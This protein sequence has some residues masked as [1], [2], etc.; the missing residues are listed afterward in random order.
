[1]AST[2]DD[3]KQALVIDHGSFEIQAGFAEED[4][5]RTAF[6]TLVGRPRHKNIAGLSNTLADSYV[7]DEAQRKRG[8]LTLTYPIERGVVTKWDDMEAVWSHT[9]SELK[10][11]PQEERAVLSQIPN[12]PKPNKEKTAE[13]FFEKFQSHSICLAN[14]AALAL[15]SSG[16]T[17]GLIV[18]SGHGVTH[19][20]PI[21][22]GNPLPPTILQMDLAGRDMD[23]ALFY[24][25]VSEHGYSGRLSDLRGVKE[26]LCYVALDPDN[27]S[28]ASTATDS[29]S[30]N[31]YELPSGETI[32]IDPAERFRIPEALF[33]PSIIKK[34]FLGIHEMAYNSISGL[35]GDVRKDLLRLVYLVGG[36]TLFRGFKERMEHELTALAPSSMKVHVIA[37][38]ERKYSVWIGGSIFASKRP[39]RDETHWVSKQ[40][41]EEIGPDV[42]HRKYL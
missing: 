25:L 18:D 21:H 26:K 31:T 17:C 2:E 7:G 29:S 36:S 19:V 8:V 27:V 30:Q 5:P 9:F 41:Y 33:K 15:Y 13:I 28:Q 1:M 23:E 3:D 22:Q 32:T 14:Q 39:Y 16:K 37:P 35:E 10:F 11:N 12:N 6:Q 42:V 40:E 20:V 4:A 38:P 24:Y 34:D